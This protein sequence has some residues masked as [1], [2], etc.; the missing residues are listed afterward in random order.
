VRG[1]L[2]R[3]GNRFSCGKKFG[4]RGSGWECLE[5][6]RRKTGVAGTQGV[7]RDRRWGQGG[8]TVLYCNVR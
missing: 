2:I 8:R 1:F 5:Y 6:S 3:R 7:E 4:N